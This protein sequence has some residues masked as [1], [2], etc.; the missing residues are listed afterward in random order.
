MK[1]KP[2]AMKELEGTD[3][4]DRA[5]NEPK[6]K[7]TRHAQPV[8]PLADNGAQTAWDYL[9][10]KLEATRVLTEPDLL[11]LADACN[12]WGHIQTLWASGEAPK[13]SDMTQYRMLFAEYGLTPASRGNV[14]TGAAD[15]AD[16]FFEGPKLDK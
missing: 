8:V 5:I 3:R 1:R 9:V 6:H 2:S 13:A 4:A 10:P 7:Q 12:Y 15:I 11:I 16:D 14:A